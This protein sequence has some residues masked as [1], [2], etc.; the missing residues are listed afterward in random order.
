MVVVWVSIILSSALVGIII[1]I[2]ILLAA[3][4]LFSAFI[5]IHLVDLLIIGL[6]NAALMQVVVFVQTQRLK[7]A[8]S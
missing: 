8:A 6:M 7:D 5:V 4:I 1:L 3:F 2:S